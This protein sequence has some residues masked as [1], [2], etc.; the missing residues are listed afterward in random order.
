MN[1]TQRVLSNVTE[2]ISTRS[3]KYF[4]K[5]RQVKILETRIEELKN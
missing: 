3:S 5:R 1:I 2:I 4:M